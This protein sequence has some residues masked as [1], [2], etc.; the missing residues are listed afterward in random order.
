M[1]VPTIWSAPVSGPAGVGTWD[2]EQPGIGAGAGQKAVPEH[3]AGCSHGLE[4][5]WQTSPGV[6]S[7]SAGHAGEVPLQLS[8]TSHGPALARQVVPA[9]A[10]ASVGQA[11]SKPEQTSAG[12]QAPALGR[13]TALAGLNRSGGHS[14]PTPVQ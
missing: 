10:R 11:D 1:L 2:R 13:Q 6:A 5:G 14:G 8:E 4:G 12:S 7:A 3:V 9:L